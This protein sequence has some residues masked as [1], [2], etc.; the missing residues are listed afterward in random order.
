[1][2]MVTNN[3]YNQVN[4]PNA[5]R[6]ICK[7]ERSYTI[8]MALLF[9]LEVIDEDGKWTLLEKKNVNFYA[10][11]MAL[12][13]SDEKFFKFCRSHW[14][15]LTAFADFFNRKPLAKIRTKSK[16]YADAYAYAESCIARL[17]KSVE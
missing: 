14:V 11:L 17:V 4:M 2:N 12:N 6:R 8:I 13:E 16:D 9:E 1:M 3:A 10:C 5:I 7:D 15:L